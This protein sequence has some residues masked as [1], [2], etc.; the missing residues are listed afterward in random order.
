MKIKLYLFLFIIFISRNLSANIADKIDREVIV[1][2]SSSCHSLDYMKMCFPEVKV[3]ELSSS[4][5]LFLLEFPIKIEIEKLKV[6]KEKGLILAFMRNKRLYTRFT[7]PNDTFFNKQT[8][9]L[10][11]INSG[12]TIPYGIRSIDAWDFRKNITT[13]HG[14]TIVIAI[15]DEGFELAHEDLDYYVNYKE[16]PN[17]GLDNDNNGAKDDYSGWNAEQ[18]SGAINSTSTTHGTSV[19]GIAGA[20]GNNKKGV[21]GVAWNVK[22]LPVN[23][24]TEG[25]VAAAIKAY[26]YC[27]KMKKK[28]IE[29]NG[30]EGAY[31]V[32]INFS[33]GREG[34]V[35]EED[36]IWCAVFNKLGDVGILSTNAVTNTYGN[37][38]TLEDMPIMCKCPYMIAV[39]TL[40]ATT[41][42]VDGSAYSKK[43]VHLA[44]PHNLY[45]TR[46]G[47]S[48]GLTGNGASTS[49]PLVC[50]AI[51]LMYSNF[52][53]IFLDSIKLYP[54]SMI[55]IIKNTILFNVDKSSTLTEFVQSGGKLNLYKSI[56][57]ATKME[58]SLRTRAEIINSSDEV[59]FYFYDKN[60][61]L[62]KSNN[63]PLSVSLYNIVGQNIFNKIINETESTISCEN[64]SS[65]L[66]ILNY[67]FGDENKVIKIELK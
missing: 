30:T 11:L 49:T 32:A 38:E 46:P 65:G 6:Q 37:S 63:L 14:D 16:I 7:T 59:Q 26:D 39:T 5:N 36:T 52:T 64:L 24:V 40:N 55:S 10:N 28:Y 61:F 12:Q 19:A 41:L 48:Y 31:I 33:I 22:I 34:Y 13:Q 9:H 42:T 44:A 1:K 4:M 53:P 67:Q 60:L 29:T 8:H 23:G 25:G 54:K 43:Y 50:G 17:D 45:T 3:S 57:A 62:K 35:P 18:N 21:A 56:L 66:Y 47:N 27:I 2:V 58:D 20:R 15:I 51:A